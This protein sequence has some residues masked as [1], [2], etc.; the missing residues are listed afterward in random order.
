LTDVGTLRDQPSGRLRI[1]ASEEAGYLLM[2]RTVPTFLERYP[3]IH[4]DVV[5]EGAPWRANSHRYFLPLGSLK[6]MQR[7]WVRSAG[8]RGALFLLR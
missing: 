7:C 2:A 6:Q 5:T 1:N 4:L 8:V 3:E